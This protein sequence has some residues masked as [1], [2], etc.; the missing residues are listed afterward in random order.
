MSSISTNKDKVP[1]LVFDV[2][3]LRGILFLLYS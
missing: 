2:L 3:D 1:D